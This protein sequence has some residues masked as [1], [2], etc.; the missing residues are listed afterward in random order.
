MRRLV[1]CSRV[2]GD[3]VSHLAVV[4]IS[5]LIVRQEP[6]YLTSFIVLYLY[7]PL[8]QKAQRQGSNLDLVGVHRAT[9]RRG[10]L[11]DVHTL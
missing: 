10:S 1:A 8:L 2:E 9:R 7:R 6:P 4:V 11:V 5:Y 3:I